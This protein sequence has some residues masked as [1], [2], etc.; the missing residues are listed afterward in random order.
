MAGCTLRVLSVLN[1]A[2]KWLLQA[3]QPGG[4]SGVPAPEAGAAPMTK[5]QQ[6]NKQTNPDSPSCSARTPLP[7]VTSGLISAT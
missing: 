3:R 1:G 6:A 7:P 5:S 4:L 2:E